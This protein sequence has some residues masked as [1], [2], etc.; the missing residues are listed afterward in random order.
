MKSACML[1]ASVEDVRNVSEDRPCVAYDMEKVAGV[2]GTRSRMGMRKISLVVDLMGE[3]D[4]FV[5][6]LLVMSLKC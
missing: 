1:G 5:T 6:S 2:C 3:A 4:R